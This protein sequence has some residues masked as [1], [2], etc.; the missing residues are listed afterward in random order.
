MY[1]TRGKKKLC[2]PFSNS[3]IQSITKRRCHS[4]TFRL[5]QGH[6]GRR[7]RVHSSEILR[8]SPMHVFH[9][10]HGAGAAYGTP[11]RLNTP[12]HVT[13]TADLLRCSPD[14]RT[15]KPR[16]PSPIP[17]PAL[18]RRPTAHTHTPHTRTH[19]LHTN[20][21][22]NDTW[23]H[24]SWSPR[25]T[26]KTALPLGLGGS[27]LPWGRRHRAALRDQAPDHPVYAGHPRKPTTHCPGLRPHRVLPRHGVH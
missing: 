14:A 10:G 25:P 9:D 8:C 26:E 17:P 2:P 18:R 1:G 16:R 3:K 4:V 5:L 6:P 21:Q 22:Q 13:L 11:P 12:S 7:H 19:A 20:T 15:K 24:A 27:P 23:D